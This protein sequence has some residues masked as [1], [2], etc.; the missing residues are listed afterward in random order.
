[1]SAFTLIMFFV[2]LALLLVG[3]ELLVRGAS[4]MA[5]ALGISPLIVGLTVVA[6]CT[7]S[8]E[9][10]VSVSSA[11]EGQ[12]D[13]A[14]GNIVGSNIVNI[15]FILGLSA[16]ITPLVVKMQLIRFDVP[17]AILAAVLV[18]VFGLNGNID[19]PAGLFLLLI[20]VAYT[21]LLIYMAR[22]ERFDV[23]VEYAREYIDRPYGRTHFIRNSAF[24]IAGLAMLVVGSNWMVDGAVALARVI[25]VSDTLI[26]LTIVAI[27]TSL[28]EAATSITAGIRGQRD[29]AVGNI[30][31]SN[32]FNIFAVLGLTAFVAPTGVPVSM[33][34]LRLEI[35]VMIAAT[36]VCVPIFYLDMK[37]TRIEGLM[38]LGSWVAITSH[39]ILTAMGNVMAARLGVVVAIC[40]LGA[41]VGVRLLSLRQWRPRASTLSGPD[42]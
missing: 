15:L 8:P 37:V 4:R 12:A 2:G 3:A 41:L 26:G 30:I 5:T 28:P 9:L 18:F 20:S 33:E 27:G 40:A 10:A 34:M 24:V 29:I 32:I 42:A 1:M 16:L 11:L 19:R 38:L 25:G 7:G 21:V 31:G 39:L 14:L 36:V 13:L 6:V 23:Q 22:R 35:P 17:I